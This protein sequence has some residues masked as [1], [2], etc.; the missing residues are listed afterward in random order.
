MLTCVYYYRVDKGVCIIR[1]E[2]GAFGA[3]VQ[4]NKVS[5]RVCLLLCIVD[6]DICARVCVCVQ[7]DP[8]DRADLDAVSIS[9][10][11]MCV[12]LSS[13][14]RSVLVDETMLDREVLLATLNI[15]SMYDASF[16]ERKRSVSGMMMFMIGRYR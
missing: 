1:G 9:K 14:A 7:G 10:C 16:E 4:S 6:D 3:F 13:T 12:V 2:G 5:Y 15:R 11:S 8:L